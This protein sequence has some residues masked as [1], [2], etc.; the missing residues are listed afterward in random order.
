MNFSVLIPVYN[1]VNPVYL[2]HALDSV[3]TAQTLKPSEIVIVEDGPINKEIDEVISKFKQLAP[4]NCL[5]LPKN[6]GLGQA[7]NKGLL[8]CRY[9]YIARMDADDI[10]LP[11][12][13][14]KQINYLKEHPTCALL[15]GAIEEFDDLKV[16]KKFIRKLPS[17]HSDILKFIE[18]RN[19]FNHMTVI[20]HK[21]A[22]MKSGSYRELSFA[23]DYYLWIRMIADGCIVHNLEEILV[24]VRAGSQMIKRRGGVKY[25]ISEW[26]LF[27][28]KKKYLKQSSLVGISY[29]FLRT[30]TRLVPWK[31]RSY[32]YAFVRT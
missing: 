2:K 31:L 30:V 21:D 24:K 4:I 14:E 18:Y 12:R 27:K 20:F 15:G 26:K 9:E 5:C 32:L 22:A 16:N 11:N 7:L 1:K 25:I 23:E 6:V 17:Y 28:I 3:W 13:F 29:L 10:A 8:A 19:S